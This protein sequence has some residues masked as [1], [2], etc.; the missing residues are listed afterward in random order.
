MA[1]KQSTLFNVDGTSGADSTLNWNSNNRI[2]F[3][4]TAADPTVSVQNLMTYNGAFTVQTVDGAT[5]S[6]NV[7]NAA[8]LKTYNDW[9]I[10]QFKSG[11]LD[12]ST[13]LS[14]FNKAFIRSTNTVD[15]LISVDDPTDDVAQS[16][17]NRIVINATG[18]NAK[19]NVAAGKTLGV[20]GAN[21]GAIRG[22]NGS[23]VTV[24]G[25]VSSSGSLGSEGS[26]VYLDASSATNNGV[27]N[28]TAS[29]APASVLPVL[30]RTAFRYKTAVPSI[31][32][33]SS[34]SP[35]PAAR[36]R[37]SILVQV[38]RQPTAAILTSG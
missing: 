21:G 5:N 32:T 10:T 37:R 13:Y 6:F 4:G 36:P 28:V 17:G 26:A 2:T 14:N 20:I 33:V 16:I 12:K 1:A 35:P 29:T 23:E 38:Q 8:G 11:N 9:L 15:Y 7:T 18:A 34:T 22:S 24:N 25:K 19:V 27:I 3:T 31:T 30:V